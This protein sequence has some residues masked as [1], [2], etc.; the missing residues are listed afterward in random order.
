MH[1][2]H[3][4][5]RRS[6]SEL[7]KLLCAVDEQ[8]DFPGVVPHL[9]DPGDNMGNFPGQVERAGNKLADNVEVVDARLAD[10]PVGAAGPS[11]PVR[12]P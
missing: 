3:T 12:G 6:K 8:P 11:R 7:P 10:P 4:A 9:E 1:Q 5:S 2:T